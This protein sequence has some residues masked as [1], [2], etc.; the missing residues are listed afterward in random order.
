MKIAI[1]PEGQP[2]I[3]LFQVVSGPFDVILSEVYSGVGI[4]TSMG[5]FGVCERDGGIEVLFEGKTV[6]VMSESG[7]PRS[8][9]EI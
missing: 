7:P 9:E 8:P 3:P 5:V 2:E 1:E 6:F 4:K